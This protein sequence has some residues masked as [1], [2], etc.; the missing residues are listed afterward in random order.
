MIVFSVSSD[1]TNVTID[2]NNDITMSKTG[3][4]THKPVKYL[5]DVGV[6]MIAS[7]TC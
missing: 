6:S 3:T 1:C 4:V 7:Q 2:S 5:Q